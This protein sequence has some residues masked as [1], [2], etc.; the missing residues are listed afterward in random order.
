M[1]PLMFTLNPYDYH[2]TCH[3]DE[4]RRTLTSNILMVTLVVHLFHLTYH[5]YRICIRDKTQING[6][7]QFKITDKLIIYDIIEQ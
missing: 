4:Q 5:R 2:E 7:R 1:L 6:S 3:K